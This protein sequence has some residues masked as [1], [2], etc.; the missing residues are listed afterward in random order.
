MHIYK[1]SS[2]GNWGVD[3]Y[4][5]GKRIRKI[6]GKKE[7]AE[8]T[9]NEII[10]TSKKVNSRKV[11]IENDVA[12]FVE[13]FDKL[14]ETKA[15]LMK[16]L[17]K[18]N[19]KKQNILDKIMPETEDKL[20]MMKDELTEYIKEINK[21]RNTFGSRRYLTEQKK[22]ELMNKYS[23]KGLTC[24]KCGNTII[25][26]SWPKKILLYTSCKCRPGSVGKYWN[27]INWVYK[28]FKSLLF[29]NIAIGELSEL[30]KEMLKSKVLLSK[31]LRGKIFYE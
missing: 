31:I 5:N 20:Q 15:I 13:A 19:E 30:E 24:F 17:N 16:R 6:I 28:Q 23:K 27:D 21:R 26:K 4:K 14:K 10:E 29:P 9:M 25:L 1:Q 18:H 3:F 2:S 22:I 8:E 12:N 11:N 7:E